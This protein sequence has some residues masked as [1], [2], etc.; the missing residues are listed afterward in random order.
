MF[1]AMRLPVAAQPYHGRLPAILTSVTDVPALG[2]LVDE[3]RTWSV[4]RPAKS[5]RGYT[6]TPTRNGFRGGGGAGSMSTMDGFEWIS[7]S[8]YSR[9]PLNVAYA[10][11]NVAVS[12]DGRGGS[13]IR[14][15]A[16][17]SWTPPKTA[18]ERVPAGDHV[19][20]VTV[21]AADSPPNVRRRVV[22]TDPERFAAI[23]SA[24]D[25]MRL[26]PIVRFGECGLLNVE[27]PGLGYY[28]RGT[29]I[30][31]VAFSRDSRSKP[32]LI[33]WTPTCRGVGVRANGQLQPTLQDGE[34]FRT[35]VK[36]AVPQ[37]R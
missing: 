16:L 19:A 37:L 22:V 18:A 4:R 36:A 34:T 2:N 6:F 31:E 17:T 14:A 11:L 28:G 21:M 9:L 7:G 1:D 8:E 26:A 20:V 29:M 23:A 30:M 33:V 15:D 25:R 12:D 3:Y 13:V 5:L 10:Q 35:A 24:F 32:N 27:V